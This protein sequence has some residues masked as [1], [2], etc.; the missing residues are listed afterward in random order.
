MG[1]LA[2]VALPQYIKSV[3]KSRATEAIAAASA[4]VSAQEREYMRTGSYTSGRRFD[5]L[6]GNLNYF[7]V[8]NYT[9]A[10]SSQSD[11]YYVRMRRTTAAGEG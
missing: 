4:I 7:T 9:A 6:I 11:C 8:V 3:E 5:V 1:I 10:C 2:S